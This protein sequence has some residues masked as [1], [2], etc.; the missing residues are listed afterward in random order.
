MIRRNVIDGKNLEP[1]GYLFR[2][3]D[4]KSP[5][6]GVRFDFLGTNSIY[7][8]S[9]KARILIDPNFTRPRRMV[10][11]RYFLKRVAPNPAII[12]DALRR[13]GIDRLDA[14]L[15]THT[16]YD[17]ALDSAEVAKQTGA[18]L[19]GSDSAMKI[20]R[21]GGLSDDK[22]LLVE[23]EKPLRFGD[24]AVKFY[25]T[26]HLGLPVVGPMV[27]FNDHIQEEIVPPVRCAKYRKGETY[28]IHLEHPSGSLLVS[29][30]GF[31]SGD[32]EGVSADAVAL[33]V[34]GLP[35]KTSD[36]REGLF[37][38]KVERVGARR[39]ILTHW[40]NMNRPL[41]EAPEFFGRSALAIENILSIAREWGSVE[42]MLIPVWGG[43]RLFG[44][45]ER[46]PNWWS[47]FW[48]GIRHRRKVR[49]GSRGRT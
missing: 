16:H 29:G 38:E 25:P 47:R 37:L 44:D 32:L 20:G 2:S 34:A 3:D 19:A 12:R 15:L 30:S 39:L 9:R 6:R 8:R 21:G 49:G 22:L 36:Y 11:P 33:C 28:C 26:V 17:H 13:A 7:L 40:D 27:D 4:E 24:F 48:N 41:K 10:G 14:V 35:L 46:A 42:V 18:V 43:I 45:G 1:F 23:P 31:R 5:G